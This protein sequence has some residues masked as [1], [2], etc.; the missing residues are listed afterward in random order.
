[1]LGPDHAIGFD[2]EGLIERYGI[3]IDTAP[4]LASEFKID[5]M[6]IF[7][8]R[9]ILVDEDVYNDE[10]QWVGRLRFTLMHELA[11]YILHEDY[12]SKIEITNI[13]SW[14]R[15]IQASNSAV[16]RQANEFAGRFLVPPDR[17]KLLIPYEKDALLKLH[18]NILTNEELKRYI[19]VR[20]SNRF[21]VSPKVIEIRIEKENLSN[22]IF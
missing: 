7:F 17:L 12:L 13:E 4:R 10:R 2:V 14:C 15:V 16:E 18:G 21:K 11:H 22:L 1:L 5:A 8:D 19:Q 3:R 20:I 9:M 6:P